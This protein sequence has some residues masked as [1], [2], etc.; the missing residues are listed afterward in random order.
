[1][2]DPRRHLHEQGRRRDEG[3][4]RAPRPAGRARR[5]GRHFSRDLRAH[6]AQ[7]RGPRG[8]PQGLHHLRR[9]RPARDDQPRALGPEAR[10]QALRPEEGRGADQPREA[11]GHLAR[12]DAVERRL[13]RGRAAHLRDLRR[14]DAR[15]G[16][17]RLRRSALSR[18]R[19]R[20]A[21]QAA[22][23]RA[24]DALHERDGRRVPRHE[25]RAI[26]AREA[27]L[28]GDAQ[29]HRGRRRRPSDLPL[30]R[31]RS[32]Q[33]PRLSEELPRRAARQAR[34]E[35][36]L[37][38]AHPAVRA[39][40][41]LAQRRPRAE[42]A[43]DRQRGGRARPRRQ[44]RRRARRGAPRGGD[45]EGARALRALADRDGHLLSDSR[46]IA[47]LRG[48]AARVERLVSG[49]RRRA[50]LRPRRGQRSA[51][52]SAR[53]LQR[54]RRRQPAAHRERADARYRQDEPRQGD[55]DRRAAR[56]EHLVRDERGG[57]DERARRDLE[58]ARVLPRAPREAARAREQRRGP[59]GARAR[60]ARR[61]ELREVPEGRRHPRGRR[62]PREPARA[63]RLDGGV[64]ARG[65]DA[66]ADRLPRARHAADLR[67]RGGL[68]RQAHADDGARGQGPRVPRRARRGP[69]GAD[70]PVPRP[71]RGRRPRGAR[72]GA[73]PR[74]RRLHARAREARAH[75]DAAAPRLRAAA[76]ELPLALP[77]RATEGRPPRALDRHAARR[78]VRRPP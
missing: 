16:H 6:S 25:S 73:P 65:R 13:P 26:A 76:H 56:R 38:Q 62:A 18:R 45:G 32:P 75:L 19:R 69:R 61:D 24:L 52:V 48:G 77:R 46:A 44:V 33:H 68:R 40:G 21:E 49:D 2:A 17:A 43:L 11:R 39:R 63:D 15:G 31:R 55:G 72:G 29:P 67:G 28:R 37:D 10:R 47:R 51:R 5:L 7:V 71:R 1:M 50:L 36:P 20:G 4:P 14:P 3:A 53:R 35:L 30:E 27:R 42:D 34:A 60:R 58:E 64:R 54:R 57:A 41:R 23:R 74:L 8:R 22:P 66:D 70:V 78:V 12:A 59:G 9:R